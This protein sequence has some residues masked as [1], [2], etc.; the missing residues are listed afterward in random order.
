MAQILDLDSVPNDRGIFE[1]PEGR[2]FRSF[3]IST[4][5][6]DAGWFIRKETGHDNV[7]NFLKDGRNNFAII[8]ELIQKPI[9]QGGGGHYKGTREQI[10]K[11]YADNS[12]G[13]NVPIYF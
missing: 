8:P 1:T 11:A 3:L 10:L 4:K 5:P 6:N 13:N 12:H 9:S 7:K 2:F